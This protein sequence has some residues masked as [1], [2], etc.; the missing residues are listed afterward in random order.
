MTPKTAFSFIA[1][2]GC[3]ATAFALPQPLIHYQFN[4]ANT[5]TTATD[6]SGNNRNGTFYNYNGTTMVQAPLQNAVGVSGKAGDYAF[7]NAAASGMGSFDNRGGA[8]RWNSTSGNAIGDLTS[9]TMSFWLK[10]DTGVLPGGGARIAGL[11]GADQ[12]KFIEMRTQDGEIL[13]S[14]TTGNSQRDTTAGTLDTEGQWL[15]VAITFDATASSNDQ[16][17]FYIG[18][19]DEEVT[20]VSAANSTL[21]S[22]ALG[23]V[24]G[25]SLT[26]GSYV[27]ASNGSFTGQ[28]PF[29]GLMDDYRLYGATSGAAGAL[30]LADLDLVRQQAINIPEPSSIGLLGGLAATA[31]I[32]LQRLKRRKHSAV[33][34]C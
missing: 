21:A 9:L 28:T 23:A 3:G 6:S 15:F 19:I 2:L 12:S 22:I 34:S 8:V 20:L 13:R 24:A 1:I 17:K 14:V 25:Q 18:G 27:N 4:D 29:K 11:Y 32:A 10:T 5:T 31:L 30:S 26:L 16:I 33:S 7:N